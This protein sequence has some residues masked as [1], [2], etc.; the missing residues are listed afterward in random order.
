MVI[1][2]YSPW[3]VVTFTRPVTNFCKMCAW[4][5]APPTS[6]LSHMF[7]YFPFP[8]W[9]GISSSANAATSKGEQVSPEATPKETQDPATPLGPQSWSAYQ[10]NDFREPRPLLFLPPAL[11]SKKMP[12]YPSSPLTSSEQFSQGYLRCCLLGLGPNFDPNKI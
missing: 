7:W 1:D 5:H 8:L 12:I 10:R 4:L 6:P 9:G 3:L 11:C 2:V